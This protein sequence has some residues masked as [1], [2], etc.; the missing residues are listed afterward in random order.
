MIWGVQTRAEPW[1]R[2]GGW[3]SVERGRG[4]VWK[5]SSVKHLLPTWGAERRGTA[6]DSAPARRR[7]QLR[8][9]RQPEVVRWFVGLG[10]SGDV[11]T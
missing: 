7:S 10:A 1:P 11:S 6:R 9:D 5:Q 8:E 4:F 3:A 2:E